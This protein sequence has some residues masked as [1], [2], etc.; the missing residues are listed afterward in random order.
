MLF[1]NYVFKL[2]FINS[3]LYNVFARK[4]ILIKENKKNENIIKYSYKEN[5]YRKIY[6]LSFVI[7]F[8][9]F[10]YY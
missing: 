3:L 8:M 7:V 6:Y 4:H 1:F 5:K 9:T 2:Q 10:Y